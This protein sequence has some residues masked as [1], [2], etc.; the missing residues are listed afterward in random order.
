MLHVYIDSLANIREDPDK[1]FQCHRAFRTSDYERFK[2]RN[3]APTPDTCQWLLQHHRYTSWRDSVNSG[4]LWVSADPGCGKSVLAKHLYDE[5]LRPTQKRATCYFFFKDDNEDQKTASNALCALLHQLFT[6]RPVLIQHA[7][8]IFKDNGDALKSNL[9]L[10]W[11]ILIAVS[12]DPQAGEIVCILDA[13]DE[14]MESELNSLLQMLCR[15]YEKSLGSSSK[16]CMKFLVTS[17]PLQN[18]ESKFSRMSY[19][20]P[21]IRLAGEEKTGEIRDEI[22][23][24]IEAELLSIQH[25]MY[26]DSS[27]ISHLRKQITKVEHRTYLWL[28]LIFELIRGDL[29]S[30]TKEGRQKLFGSIPDS[31]DACYTAILKKSTDTK[32]AKNLLRIVCAAVRPLSVTE[33]SI[34]LMIK[35]EYKG[36]NDLEIQSKEYLSR[37]IRNL[38]GLFVSVIDGKVYL[39]H[40]T[41]REFLLSIEDIDDIEESHATSD[42]D[43]H[44]K[45]SISI[46]DSNFLLAE[47]CMWYLTLGSLVKPDTFEPRSPDTESESGSSSETSDQ[48]AEIEELEAFERWNTKLEEYHFFEYAATNWTTH[49]RE[50]RTA[51]GNALETLALDL[52]HGQRH[53][54]FNKYWAMDKGSAPPRGLTDLHLASIFGLASTVRHLLTTPGIDINSPDENTFTP[55]HY[56]IIKGRVTVV[57]QLLADPRTDVN[58][59]DGLGYSPL[60][61]AVFIGNIKI[62]QQLLAAP[63]IE[64]QKPD[65]IG[66]TPLYEAISCEDSTIF[67]LLIAV[68]IA[69]PDF[70]VNW[71]DEEGWTVLHQAVY[72]R[73]PA[74]VQRLVLIPEINL[75]RANYGG[76]TPLAEAAFRQVP[77][78]VELLLS[79]PGI[80]PSLQTEYGETP[81]TLAQTVGCDEI[82]TLL[83][84]VKLSANEEPTAASG[85]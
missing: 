34:A 9:H 71:S 55:L 22:N 27:S 76:Y 72:K 21:S 62:V 16:F 5:E 63:S 37:L 13:L 60:Y 17:R 74:I 14:C 30:V 23:L 8:E 46:R 1:N 58:R 3:P 70:D 26:L 54:W 84:N 61:K 19:K 15:F 4:L 77:K 82:I 33:T 12:T 80:N 41:A 38:C 11:R 40:Q 47:K 49:F 35:P 79:R 85:D 45:H 31:V 42:S 36:H 57:S 67:E 83:E 73:K 52:S 68:L 24:V 20:M 28:K 10:L 32:Q 39:L 18:I 64:A 75:N 29:Q 50:A 56:A 51:P 43:L 59:T 48:V 44:W 78:I 6:Q 81:L 66:R 25:E 7:L 65:N 53:T 69:R 2:D